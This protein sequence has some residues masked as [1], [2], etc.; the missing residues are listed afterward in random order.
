MKAKSTSTTKNHLQYEIRL[1]LCASDDDKQTPE[2]SFAI[3]RKDIYDN[4]LS[5]SS[6]PPGREYRDLQTCTTYDRQEFQQMLEDAYAG[7]FTHL[8]LY[9]PDRFGRDF[10]EGLPVVK[11]LID[12]GIKIRV[13]SSP[14]L[15]PETPEGYLIF[16][17]Q[18][19]LAPLE[20]DLRRIRT[21]N[22]MQAKLLSGGWT[23]K[24]PEGYVNTEQAMSSNKHE[25]LIEQHP[26]YIK[27]IKI[28]WDL[29]LTGK[30][31]LVQICQELSRQGY[32]RSSGRSWAWTDPD[33]GVEKYADAALDKIFHNPFYAGWVV[34]KAFGIE[35]GHVRG[36][37]EPTISQDTFD[38]GIEILTE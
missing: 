28:A 12:L 34:S 3:Q 17:M 22:G 13:A 24:A 38:R 21:K 27:P 15:K 23:H 9:R 29:L 5:R 14:S 18:M 37:W 33:T 35:S 25:R 26:E 8:A 16:L 31:T 6:I 7:Q 30:Y 36:N 10:A 11:Q 2:R 19:A 20:A 1:Y 4:L 32:V